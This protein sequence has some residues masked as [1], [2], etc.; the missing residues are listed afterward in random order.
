M[1]YTLMC[2]HLENMM[3]KKWW[4]NHID[5]EDDTYKTSILTL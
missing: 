3:C 5:P 2:F 1:Y 4:E